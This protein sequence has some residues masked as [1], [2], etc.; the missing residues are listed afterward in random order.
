ML[1]QFKESVY[2]CSTKV[3]VTLKSI[4]SNLFLWENVKKPETQC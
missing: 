2:L 4:F 3:E 1:A